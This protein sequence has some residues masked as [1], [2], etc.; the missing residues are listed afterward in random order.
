[1]TERVTATSKPY[2]IGRPPFRPGDDDDFG[3]QFTEQ[4]GDLTRPDPAK[5][6]AQD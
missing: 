2:T 3:G 5:C 6:H 1:M 4:P